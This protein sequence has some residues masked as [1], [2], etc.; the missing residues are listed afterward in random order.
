ML[1]EGE[2]VPGLAEVSA[3]VGMSPFHFQRV[4]K[5]AV[6]L[7]PRAYAAGVRA[8]RMRAA[9]PGALSVTD[10]IYAAGYGSGSRFYEQA[11]AVLGMTATAVRRGAA[12][13]VLR[14]AVGECSLGGILVASSVKGVVAILLGDDP[15]ILVEELQGRFPQAELVGADAAYERLVA[16]VVGFVEAPGL[17]LGLPLDIRGTAFQQR[18]WQAL[19]EIPAGVVCDYTE[20]ARRIGRPGAVR[21]VG[22]ACGANAL[23][24]AIPCHRVVRRDGGLAG[25]RWGVER[26]AALLERE[27]GIGMSG[28]ELHE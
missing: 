2:R 12:R 18:V 4:F 7:S 23:A 11:E 6:G 20:V 9:L 16:E 10:A 14:F 17:G 22:A 28:V 27:G 13:E 26:K 15:G 21:A 25:Y 8:G 1:E 5:A 3:A 19:R 24:V